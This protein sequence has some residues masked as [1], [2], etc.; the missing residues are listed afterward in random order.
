MRHHL[1]KCYYGFK[2]FVPRYIQIVM[3]RYVV[4]SKSAG[5]KDFWP[6]D[7]SGG[8]RPK[9]WAGWPGGKK[10]AVVLTHD[11]ETAPGQ[12]KCKELSE[13][14]RERGF[15]SSFNFVPE[16]YAVSKELRGYLTER[17]YEIGVHDL[18]HDGKLYR[19]RDSF[20]RKAEKINHYLKEWNAVGFRSGAMHHNLDWIHDL[21]ITYDASTFDS[22]PFEPQP[23]GM[24]TIFPAWIGRN[25][26]GEGYV[27]L[28]YTLPQDFTVFVLLKEKNIEIWKKKLDWIVKK[29]GMVLLITHPDYMNFGNKKIRYDEYPVDYYID[30]LDYIKTRYKD[31]YWNVLPR[32]LAVYIKEQFIRNNV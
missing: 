28:P 16:R 26:S 32:D 25:G 12:D 11:V 1:I 18:K 13:I 19:S 14:E 23:D 8:G 24:G 15:V 5:F 9:H 7:K 10:F 3:R 2:P 22:D 30:L 27:E 4:Q 6:I 21:N 29:G 17:G 31:Q 20:L